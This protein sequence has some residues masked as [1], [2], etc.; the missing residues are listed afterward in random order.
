MIYRFFDPSQPKFHDREF[1]QD[2]EAI[3][4]ILQPNHRERLLRTLS[5]VSFV[6]ALDPTC[7][8][9]TDLG[10]GTGGL[11]NAVRQRHPSFKVQGFDLCP[12]AVQ[13][14][15]SIYNLD[16]S[17][18]DFV[19]EPVQVGQIVVLAEVLEH[20]VEPEKLLVSLRP[21]ARWLVVSCPYGE[22]NER[23]YEYHLWAWDPNDFIQM[24]LSAGYGFETHAV[25]PRVGT[26]F[27]IVRGPA[28]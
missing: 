1:Y 26:Q 2:R 12:Q 5:D 25:Y 24:F 4:H 23:H 13:Y 22:N 28:A 10:C 16:V 3:D 18:V 7:Q 27:V 19:N 11:L 17:C 14:A 8:T 9:L 15:Q 21:H 20:L 6:S